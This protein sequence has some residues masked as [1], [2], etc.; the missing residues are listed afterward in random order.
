MTRGVVVGKFYPFH[1]G[2]QYVIDTALS[3]VDALTVIVTGKYGQIINPSIRASWIKKI[4]PKVKVK[5]VYHDIAD[6]DDEMW[7][8]KTIE[9]VGFKPDMVF[10]SEHYG[11]H[12]AEQIG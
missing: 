5:L 1:L 11:D 3:R 9:W 2:H 8:K 6:N 7:A 4:Y 12:W 10:T